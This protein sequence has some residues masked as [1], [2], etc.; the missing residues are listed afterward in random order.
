MYYIGDDESMTARE[1]LPEVER[2]LESLS[3]KPEWLTV[4]LMLAIV[5]RETIWGHV[6]GYSIKGSPEGMGDW[7]K[8]KGE[9]KARYHGFGF[10]Q[11]DIG[12]HADF[13]KTGKWKEVYEACRY[14]SV[15]VLIGN[16][17]WMIQHCQGKNYSWCQQDTPVLRLRRIV[18]GYN[19]GVGNSVK[20][21]EPDSRTA[22]HNY[23]RDVVNDRLPTWTMWWNNAKD[24]GK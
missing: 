7:S 18:A 1:H 14:V 11:I 21:I 4:P 24:D 22:H 12:V 3:D 6:E 2:A 5:S 23:S 13:I 20:E 10:F 15:A 16:E 8:R 17:R 19:C 9:E